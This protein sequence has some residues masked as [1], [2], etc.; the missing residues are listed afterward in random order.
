[1]NVFQT[2]F[3]FKKMYLT[4]NNRYLLYGV[5]KKKEV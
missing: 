2:T 4:N 5:N 3:I 1:M